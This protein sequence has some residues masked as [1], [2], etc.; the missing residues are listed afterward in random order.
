M[1]NFNDTPDPKLWPFEARVDFDDGTS[2]FHQYARDNG[3]GTVTVIEFDQGFREAVYSRE[4]VVL[5]ERPSEK[6][7]RWYEL[8]DKTYGQRD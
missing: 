2:S 1:D 6:A 7:E 8:Y 3:D 4:I 5:G